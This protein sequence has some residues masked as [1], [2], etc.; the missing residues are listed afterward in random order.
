MGDCALGKNY[1]ICGRIRDVTGL[2]EANYNNY[3]NVF[4]TRK[5]TWNNVWECKS[6]R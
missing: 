6:R 2:L 3:V 1:N 4:N 5:Q